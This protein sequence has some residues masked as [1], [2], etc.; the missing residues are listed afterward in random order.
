M[1][2]FIALLFGLIIGWVAEW[3]ID[4]FYWRRKNNMLARQV[5][6]LQAENQTLG[7]QLRAL[8]NVESGESEAYSE[9]MQA[10]LDQPLD[11]MQPEGVE[12][13]A[14]PTQSD[15]W[16]KADLDTGEFEEGSP[17]EPE[18]LE[19]EVANLSRGEDLEFAEPELDESGVFEPETGQPD[20]A[21]QPDISEPQD[22]LDP[23]LED[24]PDVAD[25]PAGD[26]DQAA[27][28]DR[29]Q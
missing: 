25:E 22:W 11:A 28:I 27:G 26:E 4:W 29:D 2:I 19:P 5:A 8:S 24:A 12:V 1:Q 10:E 6:E 21:E 13:E 14:Q 7:N 16:V 23:E 20:V 3:L 18:S 9:E 17:E 15:E